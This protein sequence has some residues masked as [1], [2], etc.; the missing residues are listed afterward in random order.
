MKPSF[1]LTSRALLRAPLLPFHRLTT[2]L[3]DIASLKQ[4]LSDPA[5]YEALYLA[6]P[7]LAAALDAW[8]ASGTVAP[9]LERALV[10]Y[11]S[12]M[13]SRATPFG[14]FAGVAVV[15]AGNETRIEFAP[16]ARHRRHTRLDN[17]YLS[18]LCDQLSRDSV[19]RDTL[20]F[21]PNTSLYRIAEKYRYAELRG[22]EN[23]R[24]YHL[25]SVE[26]TEY[27]ES[28]LNRCA[29][30]ATLAELAKT[31][32]VEAE[33]SLSEARE[34]ITE[35]A[36]K[37]LIIS[38]LETNVTGEEPLSNLGHLLS[39]YSG[40]RGA[41][42]TLQSVRL[43]IQSIDAS[44]LGSSSDRYRDVAAMLEALPAKVNLQRLFQADLHLATQH[45]TLG[46]QLRRELVRGTELL[47]R[48]ND[49]GASEQWARFRK[50]FAARYEGREVPLVEVLD[51][52]TGIGFGDIGATGYAPLIADLPFPQ[53]TRMTQT[54]WGAREAHLMWLLGH[55]I[56][57]GAHEIELTTSDIDTL[58]TG[59]SAD[60]PDTFVLCAEVIAESAAAIDRGE[61]L[62]AVD[63]VG[64]SSAT[65]MLGRFCHGSPNITQ[66]VSELVEYENV[67]NEGAILAEIVHLPEGRIGNILL[68]PVL[69]EFEIPFLAKSGAERERQLPIT[70]LL[71]SLTPSGRVILRSSSLDKEVRPQI[72]AA[73]NFST[74][75]L[76]VYRFLCAVSMQHTTGS[77]WRWGAL[78]DAPFLPRVRHG[79]IV[80]SRARWLV[81]REELALLETAAKGTNR[82][83][84]LEQ[85]EIA[86][87][88]E[89]EAVQQLRSARG[90]PRW[91]VVA[92]GD[93]EMPV[94]LD[95]LLAVSSFVHLV[96]KRPRVEL[97]ELLPGPDKL[98]MVGE[99]GAFAHE[100]IIP[101]VKTE[102]TPTRIVP[103]LLASQC[104]R[105][106]PPGS[107]WLFAKL[108][109]GLSTLETVLRET[110]APFVSDV[111]KL[112]LA[113]NFF[114]IRYA[115][116]DPHIRIRFRGDPSRLTGELLPRLTERCMPLIDSGV[117]WRMQLDTYDRE[118]ERYGGGDGIE[119]AEAVFAADS[120]AVLAILTM[121]RGD[122]AAQLRWKLAL[123]GI[124][125]L[126]SDF[127]LNVLQRYSLMVR[128][129]D[130]F[131]SE[132][133]ADNALKKR[134]GAKFRTQRVALRELLSPTDSPNLATDGLAN[135][136]AAIHTRSQRNK[137]L[138]AELAEACARRK[139]AL[140]VADI[141]S[142]YVHMH[143]NR[144]LGTQPRRHEVVL[145]D[146]LSRHY[147]GIIARAR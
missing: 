113:D 142:S 30:G 147:D 9:A 93:N 23:E 80:F 15:S 2:A 57:R 123:V 33:V 26:T 17:D 95:N 63:S 126:L 115:D 84:T 70:D 99:E 132:A 32:V 117:V 56:A 122:E 81:V 111:Q 51:E 136:L 87:K 124:D 8:R 60:L 121:C 31:L 37:Q 103:R 109:A 61:F 90:L 25:V 34:F 47:L 78:S 86:R 145:Y 116:P 76:A 112:E 64:A 73:H 94:D 14:L 69:R 67:R 77:S 35:L 107:K 10:R 66:L 101:F 89:F 44:D 75:S 72:A 100:L 120:E 79:K 29:S 12:R 45:A 125:R 68:R 91:V 53:A 41:A 134:I 52:E 38:E 3:A 144:M 5:I 131:A 11:M 106:F 39:R 1:E 114:F 83:T 40:S 127:G 59:E 20:T 140:P 129:R 28:I 21:F 128:L 50:A 27:L 104:E 6:S 105:R 97:Y 36:N 146:L 92:D 141:V 130:G 82:V 71:V 85:Q 65:R 24:G 16:R 137:P 96:K 55:A 18:L 108:Y 119:I 62:L 135:G 7:D 133:A 19:L 88:E 118:I 49:V 139:V 74:R 48:F 54:P 43:A 143:V 46:P 42:D 4:Q 58:A 22:D 110:I 98:W 102:N 138:A 13:T